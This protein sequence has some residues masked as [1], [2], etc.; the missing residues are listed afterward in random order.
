MKSPDGLMQRREESE[1][2]RTMEEVKKMKWKCPKCGR[3]FD[4]KDQQHYCEKPQTIDEYIDQQ[5][6]KVRPRLREI[7]RIISKYGG[8]EASA[9]SALEEKEKELRRLQMQS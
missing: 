1:R 2:K 4:R 8:S 3:E 5:D 7:R 6:E 9:I